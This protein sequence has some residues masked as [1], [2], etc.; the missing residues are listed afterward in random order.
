MYNTNLQ[1]LYR[2]VTK[3]YLLKLG[4][5]IHLNYSKALLF[6]FN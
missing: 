5:K 4:F 1:C 6:D 2:T 3:R